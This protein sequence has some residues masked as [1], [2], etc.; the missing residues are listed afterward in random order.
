MSNVLVELAEATW[1]G[2]CINLINDDN[3]NW[4]F[5]DTG[6]QPAEERFTGCATA[7]VEASDWEP[8]IE[9]AWENYK[10]RISPA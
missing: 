4:A 7:I 5:S 9:A 2:G 10:R 6:M 1:N 3:G 8:T